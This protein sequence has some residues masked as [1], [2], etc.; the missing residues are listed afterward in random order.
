MSGLQSYKNPNWLAIHDSSEV[1]DLIV[2]LCAQGLPDVVVAD[3]MRKS[4]LVERITPEDVAY[5]KT[6]NAGEINGYLQKHGKQLMA[7]MPNANKTYRIGSLDRLMNMTFQKIVELMDTGD[8]KGASSLMTNYLKAQE[9]MGKSVG[10]LQT[11]G[12]QKNW[13]IE[14]LQKLSEEQ[15][16]E[17]MSHILEAERIANNA[18]VRRLPDPHVIDAEY[19]VGDA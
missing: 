16:A 1:R 2:D 15:Q 7:K 10:D 8:I 17:F 18:G 11:G 3:Q 6:R 14:T 12:E 4:G 13:M 5:Y 9:Q 19:E